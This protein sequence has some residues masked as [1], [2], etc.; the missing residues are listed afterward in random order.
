MKRIKKFMAAGLLLALVGE[1]IMPAGVQRGTVKAITKDYGLG[2]PSVELQ[3][4]GCIEFGSYW[5]DEY[6]PK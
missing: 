1:M 3:T 6:N 5:Q 2:N 4:R